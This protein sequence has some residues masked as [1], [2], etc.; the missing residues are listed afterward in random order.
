MSLS[1]LVITFLSSQLYYLNFEP[2]IRC[3]SLKFLIVSMRLEK[4]IKSMK[5]IVVSNQNKGN[6]NG[7]DNIDP[8]QL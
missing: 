3:T 4:K 5:P 8:D 7:P 6:R 1:T 2:K